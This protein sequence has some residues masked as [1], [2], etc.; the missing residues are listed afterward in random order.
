MKLR[1]I[2]QPVK[3]QKPM[4]RQRQRIAA[5]N[6]HRLAAMCSRRPQ[7]R[8]SRIG[9]AAVRRDARAPSRLRSARLW[10]A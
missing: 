8:N 10:R 1:T 7:P 3:K 6:R 9:S 5:P 4:C 2:K